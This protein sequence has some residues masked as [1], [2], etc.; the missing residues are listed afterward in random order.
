[1][2]EIEK[3]DVIMPRYD[4]RCQNCGEVTEFI[5]SIKKN[6]VN[7]PCP[8]C[9]KRKLQKLIN[10]GVNIIF[11]GGGFYRS[12]DYINQ[13]SKERGTI[14]NSD[15]SPAKHGRNWKAKR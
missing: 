2:S 6:H 5:H 12:I 13:R 11:K 1:M 8:K 9:G 10:Q 4:Y 15:G 7:K 14:H 3:G